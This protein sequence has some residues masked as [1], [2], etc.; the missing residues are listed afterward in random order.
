MK[1]SNTPPAEEKKIILT[2]KQWEAAKVEAD[3]MMKL[4]NGHSFVRILKTR[5]EF[6]GRSPSHRGT[7]SAWFQT[8]IQ[9][10]DTILLNS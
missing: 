3:R 7:C 4:N 9:K 2:W 6:C 1:T 8:F 5:C 10:L